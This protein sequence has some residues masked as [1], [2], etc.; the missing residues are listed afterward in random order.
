MHKRTKALASCRIPDTSGLIS[1]WLKYS[2]LQIATNSH[3]TIASTTND[4]CSV[5]NEVHTTNRIG[6]CRQ[7]PHDSCCPNVPKKNSFVVRATDEHVSFG[8][9]CNGVYVI[10]MPKERGGICFALVGYQL[11]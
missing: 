9:E 3:Q 4:E 7:R 1:S 5:A 11:P 6:M 8:R 2:Q 10:V